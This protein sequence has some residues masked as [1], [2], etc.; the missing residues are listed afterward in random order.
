VGLGYGK[1][2]VI[3]RDFG[4]A[5]STVNTNYFSGDAVIIRVLQDGKDAAYTLREWVNGYIK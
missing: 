5:K 3:K 2:F 1:K 4:L